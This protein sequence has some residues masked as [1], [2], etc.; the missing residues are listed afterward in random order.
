MID[1]CAAHV[2]DLEVYEVRQYAGPAPRRWLCLCWGWG[3]KLQFRL[4]CVLP[5]LGNH[6]SIES[7]AFRP[8][9]SIC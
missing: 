2:M 5:F 3:G 6:H 8:L 7:T 9:K 1:L 4:F